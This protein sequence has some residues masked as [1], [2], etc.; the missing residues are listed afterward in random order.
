MEILQTNEFWYFFIP[1]IAGFVIYYMG[2]NTKD[3]RAHLLNLFKAN[4]RIS[5]DIQNKL[6]QF[7]NDFNASEA[8]AFPE[9]N[10]TYGT[11]LEMMSEEYE[12]NLSDELYEFTRTKK[13]TKP[14]LLTMIDSLNKQNEALRLME[15]DVN[16]VIKKANEGRI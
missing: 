15:I 4:Q 6:K 12:K 14:T 2:Q 7:I 5:K 16:L 13:L 1:L 3:E 11:Y 9:R 10:L 8:I